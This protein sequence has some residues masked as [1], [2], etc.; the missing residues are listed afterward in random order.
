MKKALRCQ[1]LGLYD[2]AIHWHL[3]GIKAKGCA[4]E[5]AH[6]VIRG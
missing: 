1:A 4:I 3:E 5:R 2:Q 6:G